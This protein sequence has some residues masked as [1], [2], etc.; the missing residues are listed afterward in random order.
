[1]QF[2]RLSGDADRLSGMISGITHFILI[3][4]YSSWMSKRHRVSLCGVRLQGP[5]RAHLLELLASTGAD[6]MRQMNPMTVTHVVTS[7]V[8]ENTEK[9]NR[10]RQYQ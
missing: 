1:M 4:F 10:A 5:I 2:C 8:N 3:I 9:V 6:V 7:D